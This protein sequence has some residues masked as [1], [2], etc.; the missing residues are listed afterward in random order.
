MRLFLSLLLVYVSFIQTTAQNPYHIIYGIDDGL[1]ST[2]VYDIQ[3]DEYGRMWFATDRGV[4]VFD[5]YKFKTYTTDD[6]LGDIVIFRIF[7]D[8]NNNL[9]FAEKGGGLTFY[10][11]ES[12]QK[13]LISEIL[14]ERSYSE[15]VDFFQQIDSTTFLILH[16]SSIKAHSKLLLFDFNSVRL[17]LLTG[18]S[19]NGMTINHNLLLDTT[20]NILFYKDIQ[21]LENIVSV[22]DSSILYIQHKKNESGRFL[23]L[24]H[25]LYLWTGHMKRLVKKY[26]SSVNHIETFG[27]EAWISSNGGIDIFNLST[28]EIERSLFKDYQVS[29]IFKTQ[30]G[31]YWISTLYNGIILCPNPFVQQFSDPTKGNIV[32][33]D[34]FINKILLRREHGYGLDIYNQQNEAEFIKEFRYASSYSSYA[35]NN[36]YLLLS[37]RSKIYL[38]KN[39]AT[40]TKSKIQEPSQRVCEVLESEFLLVGTKQ[41]TIKSYQDLSTK[42]PFPLVDY[43]SKDIYDAILIRDSCLYIGT[44]NGL[45]HYHYSNG[46]ISHKKR[47][48]KE[49]LQCRVSQI[50]ELSDHELLISS[51]GHGFMKYDFKNGKV[52]Q[53]ASTEQL[54]T[55]II[56]SFYQEE[57]NIIW[58][59]TNIGLIRLRFNDASLSE[60]KDI[61]TFT[62]RDGLPTNYIN[63][64]VKYRG[65][66]WVATTSGVCYFDYKE[67]PQSYAIPKLILDSIT[68]NNASH[69]LYQELNLNHNENNITFYV[70]GVLLDHSVST[71]DQPY[72][73]ALIED[74]NDTIWHSTSLKDIRFTNLAAG[75]YNFIVKVSDRHGQ[76]S[77]PIQQDFLISPH[78]TE[79]LLFRLL[80]L[81]ILIAAI[82]YIISRKNKIQ[83]QKIRQQSMM[84]EFE[85]KLKQ[86]E[87]NAL[88]GQMNPHFIYNTL[89]SI[90]NYIF[91]ED[92]RAANHLISTFGKLIR[93]SLELSSL[94][95]I[96]I[97]QE[98]EYLEN[99][100]TLEK[101]RFEDKFDYKIRL[102]DNLNQYLIPPLLIQ[103]LV[104]NAIK[105]AFLDISLTGKLMV[106][107]SL[108]ANKITVEVLDNGVGIQ[109]KHVKKRS[110]TVSALNIIRDR[111]NLL[112]EQGIINASFSIRR[113]ND[114]DEFE[115]GTCATLVLE[116]IKNYES[117]YN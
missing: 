94:Q 115:T 24:Q 34:T 58:L 35:K 66:I 108:E 87:L 59:C 106:Q 76:W 84:K 3:E 113:R 32:K 48:D 17:D 29:G 6:G 103:P 9:W 64:V 50:E 78:F 19:L 89:N 8:D 43:G 99:Y 101:M 13:P 37:D 97:D 116:A 11:G 56:H 25:D 111:V 20:W 28:H 12:F 70:T 15:Y 26:P 74:N 69:K 82:W 105:H 57:S 88:K 38:E 114:G 77:E 53:I 23:N 85:L 39:R 90:Q 61:R 75:Q 117:P 98:V 67:M 83:A 93:K 95:M 5:G 71:S 30:A 7:K 68:I 14:T 52:T 31:E 44:D 10:D 63:S 40:L 65:N 51:I 46:F 100:L 109:Q 47:I 92:A 62:T 72:K 81:L 36:D 86:A 91:K 80:L 55:N 2:Q 49:K 18:D 42:T 33:L 45:L 22:K 102:E 107:F 96:T 41:L 112:N 60:I 21:R 4:S 54:Q 16:K 110:I 79:T 73:Y 27:E 1:P 104:E